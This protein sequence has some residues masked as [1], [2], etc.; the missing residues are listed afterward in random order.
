[1]YTEGAGMPIPERNSRHTSHF[2]CQGYDILDIIH[3]LSSSLFPLHKSCNRESIFFH[4]F[5][6]LITC[7]E[8]T[9]EWN[10]TVWHYLLMTK[11]NK[12][13]TLHSRG[14]Q[15]KRSKKIKT[16]L[17]GLWDLS[18]GLNGPKNGGKR[19][20]N[21]RQ[22]CGSSLGIWAGSAYTVLPG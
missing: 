17:Q 16:S 12:T 20:S 6:N 22:P 7:I 3:L 15:S 2:V 21:Q 1:M 19:I 18:N 10:N 4:I 8:R 14:L 5:V 9:R 13:R 11:I